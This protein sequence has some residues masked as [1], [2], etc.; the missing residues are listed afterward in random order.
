MERVLGELRARIEEVGVPIEV[1]PGGEVAI[2]QLDILSRDELRR[3]GLGGNPSYLLVETPYRGWPLEIEQQFF[4][5]RALGI[6]PVLAHPER[7]AEVQDDI[8]RIALSAARLR[9]RPG[10]P[11]RVV[12]RERA[13]DVRTALC[14]A[15]AG[16]RSV[17]RRGHR[18]GPRR[19]CDAP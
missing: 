9:S 14:R 2:E 12:A 19:P 8:E 11:P 16:A 3:F 1:L 10:L 6:T 18:V 5:L 13:A 4:R 7:N 15:P 17:A